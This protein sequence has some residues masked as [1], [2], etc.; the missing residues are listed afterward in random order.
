VRRNSLLHEILKF[1]DQFRARCT[2][3]FEDDEYCRSVEPCLLFK[4]NNGGFQNTGMLN[5]SALNL[6]R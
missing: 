3:L 1:P 2:A 4:S 5:Q 6:D